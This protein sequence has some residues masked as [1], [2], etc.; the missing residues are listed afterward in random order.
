M[1][2][3]DEPAEPSAGTDRL[4]ELQKE[5]DVAILTMRYRPYNLV[6]PKLLGEL[7]SSLQA[8]KTDGARA[9]VI[10]SALRHFSAG[11]D[12]DQFSAR[13]EA[14][15]KRKP[16]ETAGKKPPRKSPVVEFLEELEL[17]PIPIIASVHGV[18]LGGGLELALACDY[19][20]AGQSAKIGSVEATLGL[21]PLMGA[22]QRQVQRIGM[23][24]AKEMS[25]LARRYDAATMCAW[26][27][28]NLCV[29][30]DELEATT[31]SVAQEFAHGPTV[32][33]AA[34]KKLCYVAANE[35][36]R[37]ADEA[38]ADIQKPIWSSEDLMTGLSSFTRNGP[39]LAKFQGK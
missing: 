32:S 13:A 7:S 30:D 26:G 29:A 39:G 3:V 5:G 31:M 24:R 19:V 18:C 23:T 20:I 22:T 21:H 33:Y 10:R 9:I 6:G 25:M 17:L 37:A 12:L 27:L 34:T 36:V 1:E 4:I 2:I 15:P 11:A 14:K 8:A 38:M 35:G 16:Q 28:I